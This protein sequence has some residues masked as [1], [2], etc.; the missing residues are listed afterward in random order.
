MLQQVFLRTQGF[1]ERH[2]FLDIP[3]RRMPSGRLED[4]GTCSGPAPH[5]SPIYVDD[6][7]GQADSQDS[8]DASDM[9]NNEMNR[10]RATPL[11]EQFASEIATATQS[12]PCS[13]P[14]TPA[15]PQSCLQILVCYLSRPCHQPLRPR[16]NNHAFVGCG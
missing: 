12:S 8:D 15:K 9:A 2:T 6:N 4:D 14:L 7:G 1:A 16:Q 13:M 10:D 3:P 5:S 11:S